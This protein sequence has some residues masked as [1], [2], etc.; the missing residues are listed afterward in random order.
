MHIWD[1]I[2]KKTDATCLFKTTFGDYEFD[3]HEHVLYLFSSFFRFFFRFFSFLFSL[4]LS[5]D[6]RRIGKIIITYAAMHHCASQP[7]NLATCQDSGYKRKTA[8]VVQIWAV[9]INRLQ[10][11][12]APKAF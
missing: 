12:T 2:H 10:Q 11:K 9:K 7:C 8:P 5:L 6:G 4:S 1:V 3:S